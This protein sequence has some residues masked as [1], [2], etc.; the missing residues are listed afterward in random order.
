MDALLAAWWCCSDGGAPRTN[1]R[2]LQA[3]NGCGRIALR[4]RR[5]RPSGFFVRLAHDPRR[6]AP[7]RSSAQGYRLHRRLQ[8]LLRPAAS[9]SAP[10]VARPH[11]AGAGPGPGSCPLRAIL[12]GQGEART[13]PGEPKRQQIYLRALETLSGVSIHY[14]TF[15]SHEVSRPLAAPMPGQPPVVRVLDTEEKGSD[16]NLATFLLV[17]G[18]DGTWDESF[19]VTG[20]SDLAEPI[21]QAVA[22]FGPVHVRNPRSQPSRELQQVA[23]S[24]GSLH[25]STLAACQLPDRVRLPSGRWVYRPPTW[26]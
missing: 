4:P 6:R 11:G 9:Q 7:Y 18:M 19:V 16:V 8:P 23:S 15:L 12:H 17:D 24:Y 20:D 25:I 14:G 21:R 22:R 10:E 13:D 1:G 5:F 26:R 2:I 3:A